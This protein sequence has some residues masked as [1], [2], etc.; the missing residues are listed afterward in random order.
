MLIKRSH[1]LGENILK[2]SCNEFI[3]WIYKEHLYLNTNEQLTLKGDKIRWYTPVIPALKGMKQEDPSP[4]PTWTTWDPVPKRRRRGQNTW[5][6]SL[7][8]KSGIW[9][10]WA[11][12]HSTGFLVLVYC[13]WVVIQCHE[14]HISTFYHFNVLDYYKRQPSERL[15]RL[16]ACV[17]V[18]GLI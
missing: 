13:M 7:S 9:K 4:R 6:A 11:D 10:L 8:E 5:I 12:L 18:C 17:R 2:I 16:S 15:E 14:S 1:K 3:P